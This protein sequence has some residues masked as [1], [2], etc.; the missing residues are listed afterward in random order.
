MSKYEATRKRR[1]KVMFDQNSDQDKVPY[2]S[3]VK[4]GEC[5][6]QISPGPLEE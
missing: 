4:V 5:G 3:I 2:L 6:G 1:H